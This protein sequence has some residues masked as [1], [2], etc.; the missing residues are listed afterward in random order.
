MHAGSLLL[1]VNWSLMSHG[2][3]TLDP[4]YNEYKN[5]EENALCNQVF[6]V[7]ELCNIAVTDFDKKKFLVRC[8]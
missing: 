5:V 8:N 3:I 2:P 7:T 1:G 4:A 6:I